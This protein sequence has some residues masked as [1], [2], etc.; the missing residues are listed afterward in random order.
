M[1]IVYGSE[2]VVPDPWPE[3]C[4]DCATL[5]GDQ[6]MDGCC[7]EECPAC[8]GQAMCCGCSLILYPI[9]RLG[10]ALGWQRYH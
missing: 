1:A 3:P 10:R 7:L 5:D 2:W 4:R 6:H 9:R 8:G